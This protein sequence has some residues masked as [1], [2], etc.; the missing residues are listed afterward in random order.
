MKKCDVILNKND[1]LACFDKKINK[2]IYHTK[3]KD[4][5]K[6]NISLK[7]IEKFDDLYKNHHVNFNDW[8]CDKEGI[9][10]DEDRQLTIYSLLTEIKANK[11]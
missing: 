2:H 11:K 1:M 3:H 10:T 5:T 7:M 4:D 6:Q 9:C 8:L